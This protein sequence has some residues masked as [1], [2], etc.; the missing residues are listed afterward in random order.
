MRNPHGEWIWFELLTSDPDAA[1]AFYGNVVGWTIE[2]SGMPDMDYRILHAGN[3]QT[4]GLMK[5]P[6]GMEPGPTWLGY[7]GVD[8]VDESANA[9]ANAGGAIHMPPTSLP[10]VGR[11]AMV[12]DPQGAAFY[13]M[14]G[15]S[16][17]PSTAFRQ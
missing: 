13:V 3:G 4:G 14:R 10:G 17:E 5:M 7:I 2:A 9:I 6:A 16:P 11:M 12:T 15:D 8:D 1:Q